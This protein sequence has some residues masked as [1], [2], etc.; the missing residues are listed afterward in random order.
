MSF[1]KEFTPPQPPVPEGSVPTAPPVIDEASGKGRLPGEE[2]PKPATQQLAAF[3]HGAGE[4][5]AA[6]QKAITATAEKP[7]S[8]LTTFWEDG[9]RQRQGELDLDAKRLL[10]QSFLEDMAARR[11]YARQIFILII[12][13]LAAILLVLLLQGF[14]SKSG[15]LFVLHLLGTEWRINGFQLADSVLLALIGGTTASVLGLFAIV[16]KYFFP[17][18]TK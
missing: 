8:E 4:V 16:A 6:A 2:S 9:Q 7:V 11:L 17:E 1:P 12:C 15:A 3:A 18:K 14:S 10:N 5:K 13:W